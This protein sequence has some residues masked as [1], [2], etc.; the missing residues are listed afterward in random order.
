[1]LRHMSLGAIQ[2]VVASVAMVAA[3]SLVSIPQG[4]DW[5]RVSTPARH[6]FSTY[7]TTTVHQQDLVQCA[8][9]SLSE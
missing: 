2:G 8:V 6:Y 1:M 7:I 9:L 4:G 3:V 5:D